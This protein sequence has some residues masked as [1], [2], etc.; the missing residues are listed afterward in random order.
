MAAFASAGHLPPVLFPADNVAE[1]VPVPVGPPL[2]TGV[3]GY[4]LITR[5]MTPAQTLLLFTDGLVERR[6]EDIDVSLARLAGQWLRPG[7]GVEELLDTVVDRFDA[8]HAEDDV[9][10][11]AARICRR[12]HHEADESVTAPPPEAI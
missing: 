11:L 1:V 10:V 2:G 12:P 6:G 9:A 7:A 8:Q 4:E 5:T 3:G